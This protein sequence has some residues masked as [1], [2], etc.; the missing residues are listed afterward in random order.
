MRKYTLIIALASFCALLTISSCKKYE[1]GPYLSFKSREDRISNTWGI[2]RI[3]KNDEELTVTQQ[4]GWKWTFSKNGTISRRFFF[5]GIHY[6]ANGTWSLESDDEEIH[7]TLTSP[8]YDEDSIWVITKLME[9]KLWV[10]YSD[11]GDNYEL[12]LT[13]RK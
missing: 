3:Y 13:P 8:L 4:E 12:R 7:I 6:I 9:D 5:M 11:N 2:D 1:E 10:K